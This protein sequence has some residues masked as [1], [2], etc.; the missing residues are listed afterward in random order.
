MRRLKTFRRPPIYPKIP[1]SSLTHPLPLSSRRP[2]VSFGGF[3]LTDTL[4]TGV[5]LVSAVSSQGACAASGDQV[6]CALG[7]LAP[8][9]R[10][11]VSVVLVPTSEGSIK[12]R[13]LVMAEDDD[14]YPPD[15]STT[16][17]TTVLAQGAAPLA[18]SAAS[19]AIRRVIDDAV[20]VRS[21]SGLSAAGVGLGGATTLREVPSTAGPAT[22][23]SESGQLALDAVEGLF[24]LLHQKDARIDGLEERLAAMEQEVA[25]EGLMSDLWPLSSSTLPWL[26]GGGVLGVVMALSIR[27]RL[28]RKRS[29]A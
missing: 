4:P 18:A 20:V 29:R 27:G 17:Y 2:S 15:S 22:V 9:E 10:A 12:N 23:S 6:T 26:I 7:N 3:G 13:A 11:R 19:S 14:V 21:T 25:G 28:R 5:E 8:G 16:E 24:R 1:C